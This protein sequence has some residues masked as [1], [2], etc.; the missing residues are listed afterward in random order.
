MYNL[1]KE[2]RVMARQ[3]ITMVNNTA[4]EPIIHPWVVAKG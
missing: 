1:A 2:G 4:V 3:K